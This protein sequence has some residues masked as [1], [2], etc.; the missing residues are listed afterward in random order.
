MFKTYLMKL[1][2]PQI[3]RNVAMSS[4]SSEQ[5]SIYLSSGMNSPKIYLSVF[6]GDYTRVVAIPQVLLSSKDNFWISCGVRDIFVS[7]INND[8]QSSSSSIR[9]GYKST[10]TLY[11]RPSF[12]TPPIIKGGALDCNSLQ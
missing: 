5:R 7:G 11:K 9:N 4:M 8:E 2:L 3:E 12:E 1:L 6:S 10:T